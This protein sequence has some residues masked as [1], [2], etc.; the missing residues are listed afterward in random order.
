MSGRKT[1]Q[2]PA[3]VLISVSLRLEARAQ[4]VEKSKAILGH[5]GHCGSNLFGGKQQVTTRTKK[6]T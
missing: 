5:V 1:N 6:V 4:E 3:P 2:V